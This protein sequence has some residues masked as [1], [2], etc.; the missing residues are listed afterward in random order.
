[1][2]LAAFARMLVRRSNGYEREGYVILNHSG[3]RWNEEFYL[4]ESDVQK[5]AA[6][7]AGLEYL[8]LSIVPATEVV[9]WRTPPNPTPQAEGMR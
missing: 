3:L 4:H 9:R 7:Y 6:P 8:S 2:N 5:A 1:M